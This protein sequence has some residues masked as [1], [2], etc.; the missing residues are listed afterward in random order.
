M[1]TRSCPDVDRFFPQLCQLRR[2]RR[3]RDSEAASTLIH[4]FVFSRVDYCNCLMAGAPKKWTEKLQRVMNTAA[5]ILT[6]MKKYD[7]ER[8]QI[9]HDE[10]H[11]LDVSKRIQ[12]M[13][14]IHVYK[15]LHGIAPKYT[16][17]LC[18]PVSAIEGRY[19]LRSAARGQLDV[20]RPKMSTYGRR[21]FSYVGRSAWN[22]LPNYLKDS[23]LTLVT[24]K[25][26]LKTFLFSKY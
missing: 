21:A 12:F 9:L 6:Q 19:H 4:S 7:R 3:S 15:C 26:S 1:S 25:R 22:S 5:R 20:P 10:L 18:R 24:F 17:D 13:L 11:W 8:T 14:C 2:V 23:S 16:M